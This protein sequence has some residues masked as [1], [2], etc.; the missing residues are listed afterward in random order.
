MTINYATLDTE[1]LLHK[2]NA[3]LEKMRKV[4]MTNSES[5]SNALKR[6]LREH[7]TLVKELKGRGYLYN[8]YAD[9]Y[10]KKVEYQV[11]FLSRS[12]GEWK[13]IRVSI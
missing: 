5:S 6:Y 4:S 1:S 3:I 10:E 8:L 7:R 9:R 2:A 12:T 13:T 11:P